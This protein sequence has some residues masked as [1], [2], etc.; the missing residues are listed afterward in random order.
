MRINSAACACSDQ[1]QALRN[2][3][4]CRDR[5]RQ[6]QPF[7]SSGIPDPGRFQ[8]EQTALVIQEAL[9]NLE[10]LAVLGERFGAR[11]FIT[12][13][14]PLLQAVRRAAQ[15]NMH[16]AE[17]LPGDCDVVEAARFTRCQSDLARLT[18][19]SAVWRRKD[20]AGLDPE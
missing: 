3:Q 9:L 11:R 17:M 16:R 7:Q 18:K 20:Q 6:G 12:D 19:S 8:R 10:A 5:E 4:E 13:H 2:E 15:R 1:L 14:L